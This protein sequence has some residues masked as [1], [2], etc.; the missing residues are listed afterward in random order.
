M[1]DVIGANHDDHELRLCPDNLAVLES[2]NYVFSSVAAKPEVCGFKGGVVAI[3]D[4][5][6]GAFPALGDGVPEKSDIKVC[7]FGGC[8]AGFVA[9]LPPVFVEFVCWRS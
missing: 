2:P 9:G 4:S 3:P 6:P 8:D 5:F 1:T 7:P